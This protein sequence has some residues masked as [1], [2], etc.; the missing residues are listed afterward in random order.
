MTMI[1]EFEIHRYLSELASA[2]LPEKDENVAEWLNEIRGKIFRAPLHQS[3]L[4]ALET[5]RARVLKLGEKGSLK[6]RCD[7]VASILQEKIQMI[8]DPP[9]VKRGKKPNRALIA[10]LQK[11]QRGEEEEEE[12]LVMEGKMPLESNVITDICPDIVEASFLVG[13][14]GELHIRAKSS[15]TLLDRIEKVIE[16]TPVGRDPKYALEPVADSNMGLIQ[17]VQCLESATLNDSVLERDAESAKKWLEASKEFTSILYNIDLR[18][19]HL[20]SLPPQIGQFHA[21]G[22]LCLS[23]NL[24]RELPQEIYT[25][26]NL[27]ILNLE[28]N[29][30]TEISPDIQRL[31]KLQTLRLSF[32]ELSALPKEIGRLPLLRVVEVRA[33]H[34]T[35]LP[36]DMDQLTNL[37]SLDISQNRVPE[38]PNMVWN[39][40]AL[41]TLRF[42]FNPLSELSLRKDKLTKLHELGMSEDHANVDSI[43]VP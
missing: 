36:E 41:K 7:F 5:I 28:N 15:G 3:D 37:E 11:M 31:S 9:L 12:Q 20:V 21:L 1:H 17:F 24:L 32:N 13:F 26:D 14:Y 39:M 42:G 19:G 22:D 18:M 16:W 29:F 8:L 2:A 43:E 30:L 27:S 23:A 38:I 4:P 34:L 6:R 10:Q 35:A 40:T 33:N 25:L